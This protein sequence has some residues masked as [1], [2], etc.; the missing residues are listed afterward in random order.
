MRSPALIVLRRVLRIGAAAAV[1]ALLVA[2]ASA[3][4]GSWPQYGRDPAHTFTAGD[5]SGI[6]ARTVSGLVAGWSTPVPA[7]GT[8]SIAGGRVLVTGWLN[9]GPAVS[10]LDA[11]SGRR[12]WTRALAGFDAF[13][14]A[15]AYGR[16]FVCENGRVSAL[17]AAGG[18]RLFRAAACSGSVVLA[19]GR[20]FTVGGDGVLRAWSVSTGREAWASASGV[21]LATGSPVVANGRVY[22]PGSGRQSRTLVVFDAAGGAVVNRRAATPG[23]HFLAGAS[24]VDGALWIREF[25]PCLQCA[26]IDGEIDARA[27]RV[28]AGATIPPRVPIEEFVNESLPPVAGF[29]HMFSTGIGASGLVAY[30]LAAGATGWQVSFG[31]DEPPTLAAGVVYPDG[32]SALS[33]ATGRVLWTLP[34]AWIDSAPAIAGRVLYYADQRP[35]GTTSVRTF[36]LP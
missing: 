28:G 1:P 15:V 6:T 5:P 2:S 16:V 35:D 23:F 18:H 17:G 11:S 22:Q 24:I 8:P 29:G 14:P 25:Q 30:P 19:G 10:A 7:S 36:H 27:I 20:G 34:D 26:D 13:Q 21:Q 3:V 32:G 9:N 31:S 4:A 12:L 33:A